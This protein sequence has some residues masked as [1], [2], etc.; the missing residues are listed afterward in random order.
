MTMNNF[1]WLRTPT[2]KMLSW[3]R[4]SSSLAILIFIGL[5]LISGVTTH[6]A[7]IQFNSTGGS[8]ATN[9]L[10]FYIEDTTKIQVRRLNNTGQVYS[11]GVVPPSNN[12]D[13][14]VFIRANGNVYGPSHTVTAFTPTGGM[15]NT[16]SIGAVTPANPAS[17]GVQQIATG[18]FGITAGPQ[19]TVVW[20]YTTPLDFL[21]ADVTLVI[22]AGYPVS[23]A[24]PVRYYHVFD[25]FLGGS[26]SG[27]GVLFTDTNGK[28]VIGTYPPPPPGTTCPSSTS[29]PSG[30]SVVESFR[31]RSG[32]AFSRYCA[33]S[34]SSFFVNGAA[35]CSVLQAAGMSNTVVTTYQDTGIGIEY[36][37]TAPGTYTFSYDFVIGSTSVPPYDHLEIQ[38][39]GAATLCPENVTVLACTS[40]TL[41]CPAGSRVN[42]G[43]LSGTLTT[44]PVTPAIAKT[45]A[46]FTLGSAGDTATVVLQGTA[47]GGSYLLGT[48]GLSTVP[49]SGTKCW[50]TASN[51]QSCTLT[52]ANTPCVSGY[53]CLETGLSYNNLTST[54]AARNPL[55]TK[56]A[57]TNFKFD[58]V[59][60]QSSGAVASAYAA[61]ANVTVELFDDSASPQ[62]ACSAYPP[63]AVA[64]QAITF[65]AGDGGRKTLSTNFNVSNA[66]PKLRCRVKDTNLTPTVYGC[67]SDQFAVRPTS[68]GVTSS[69]NADSTG[70]DATTPSPIKTGASFT[71]SAAS[72]VVGYNGT[73]KLGTPT[74]HAGSVQVGTVTGNFGGAAL[75]TGIAAGNFSY[76]EVGYFRYPISGVYDDTFT[77]ID[78]SGDCTNDFSNAVG[79]GVDAGKYGCKFG[80]AAVTH[81]FGR[82]IPDHFLVTPGSLVNRQPATCATAS[83]FT[84]SGEEMQLKNFTLTARNALITPTVTKNYAGNFARFNGSVIGNFGLGAVDLADLTLPTAARAF[85]VGAGAGQLGLVSSSGSWGTGVTAGLGTFS[86]NLQLNRAVAPDGPYESFRVGVAPVDADGVTI[87][88]ADKNLDITAPADLVNDKVLVGSTSVRFGRLRMANAIGPETRN[89]KMNVESQYWNGALFTRNADDNCTLVPASAWSFGNYV[90]KPASVV[91]NPVATD[92]TLVG[93]SNFVMFA[94]PTGGRV[95][96]DASL[97]LATTGAETATSSCLKNLALSSPSRPWAPAVTNSAPSP[98]RPSLTHLLG[99]WC[100]AGYVNNPSARGSFGLYRGADSSIFQRENY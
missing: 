44:T 92:S 16:F 15:Y 62:P 48:S 85:A 91:F 82:F 14:G 50:N 47:P 95:T 83:N 72:G 4:C 63:P 46:S 30:V 36:D 34:W 90:K 10:H 9:G 94:K 18:A 22:P 21:T 55:Y 33:A 25:T 38:H 96:F 8:T 86:A 2:R 80:N 11:A 54:P 69:A 3:I 17:S 78:Q 75:A 53:E 68:F 89:L 7:V 66:Y 24:N 99:S 97:N 76:S 43:V 73:P 93:G 23:A 71:M 35:N 26:D 28:R 20:K 60:L 65:V 81:Y 41:P 27:C 32:P 40:S 56:L 57:G 49:L 13:N 37:F 88:S 45:P 61:A 67:S 59:A 84:Y 58:V 29:I 77:L 6:A 39:D 64:S 79:T 51:S 1:E 70:T 42:T 31:E 52:L 12:L 98:A 19:V 100:D 87:R 5:G 74:A